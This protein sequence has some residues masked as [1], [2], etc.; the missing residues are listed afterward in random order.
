VHLRAA[1]AAVLLASAAQPA[2][3]QDSAS[4]VVTVE[5][6]EVRG[7]PADDALVFRGIPFA[8]PPTGDLRWRAPQPVQPW[9][10]VRDASEPAPA[11]LQH[12]E[13]SAWNREQWLRA[14]E[15]CLTLDVRTPDLSGK[16]PVMV[17]I[18]GGSNRAGSSGGPADSDLTEHGVVAVGLQYRL[19][20][21]GFLSHTALSAEQGGASGNYGLMDQIAALRWVKDN[22]ANFGGDP[23]NVTIFGE[24]AG[25][26]DVSLLL[27]APEAQG[28]FHKA[29]MQSGTPGFGLT[30]RSLEEAE[31]IGD[32]L[33]DKAAAEGDLGKLRAL[34]PVALFALEA[35]LA[36]PEADGNGMIFL[37]TT[38]DGKVLPEAPDRLIVN[39]APKPVIIGTD[40]VEFAAD[41]P[42]DDLPGWAGRFF[43]ENA[44]EALAAYRAEQ[45]DP[46]RGDIGTRIISDATFHCPADRMADLL[47]NAG[48]PVWRYEFDIGE[49]G[50]LTR[51]A[52]EIGWVFE[53]KPVGGGVFMQDY[54]AA[55]AVSGDPNGETPAS[56]ARPKW[57]RWT[58][59]NP[60]QI[61]FG[62]QRTA[63]EPGK[64]RAALCRFTE[65]F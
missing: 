16:R 49:D 51:H 1:L 9:S 3:A 45:S 52:Y 50:G 24:S 15:D 23:D 10:G 8:A 34:S 4:P 38:I 33:G 37:R 31:A 59:A 55:L 60:R 12:L 40:K 28:L 14:S 7:A 64:P 6:G 27:A 54:W 30:W 44:S 57:Q 13:S 11:C 53:R 48:W 65:N 25:S 32:Q 35:E 43:G 20:V 2:P 58:A 17:W 39:H 36:D 5:G 26:Q 42:D 62:E 19:G 41:V 61:A 18:H 22:I 56:A 29:I 21:L 47:A 46:R 63:M